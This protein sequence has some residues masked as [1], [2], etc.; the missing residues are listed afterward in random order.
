[1]R[2]VIIGSF[3]ASVAMATVAFA[4]SSDGRVIV[5][6]AAEDNLQN[7]LLNAAGTP[8]MKPGQIRVPIPVDGVTYEVIV[9]KPGE[10]KLIPAQAK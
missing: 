8:T 3:L 5:I 9:K 10:A 1:M 7:L 6:H 2:K 4:Q